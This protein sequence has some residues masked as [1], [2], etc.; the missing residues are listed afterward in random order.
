MKQK[1]LDLLPPKVYLTLKHWDYKCT[2]RAQFK[3][4]QDM[5][6]LSTEDGYSYKP[7]DDKKS[8]FIHIPKCAGMSMAK[9]IFGNLAGGHATLEEYLNIFEPDCIANYFK[10]TV[11]RNPWDRL[12]S[13]YF[14]LK[15]GGLN[16][17]DRNWFDEELADF[18]SF[19]EFVTKWINRKNIWKMDHFRPQYH[20]MLDK[21]Q[22]IHLDYVAFIENID[23]DFACIADHVG[24]SRAL[25]ESNKSMHRSYMDYY[26]DLT[27]NI[28]AETYAED[29]TMLGYTFDNSSLRTQLSERD[30]GKIYSLRPVASM[31]RVRG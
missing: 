27:M 26:N 7:F 4:L 14:F 9:T 21:R 18:E 17:R 10:F 22:K 23:E 30:A 3:H 6:R 12:V 11:V 20:Y 24:V 16:S 13:A 1:L 25:P 31:E 28:V 8:I 29:V 5:R 19:N 15:T 2:H